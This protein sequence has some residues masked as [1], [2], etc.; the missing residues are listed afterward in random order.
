MGRRFVEETPYRSIMAQDDDAVRAC[1]TG[2]LTTPE[3]GLFV[4]ENAGL[5]VGMIAVLVFGHPLSGER[6]ASELFWWVEPEHRGGG[7]RLMKRAETWA[8]RR[9]AVKM[10]MIAPTEQVGRVYEALGYTRIEEVY[11]RALL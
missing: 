5:V 2:L 8:Q 11:Q 10:Q 3:A 7:I 6:I 1:M 9:G 4:A